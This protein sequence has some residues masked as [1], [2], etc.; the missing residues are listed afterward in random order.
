MHYTSQ[1]EINLPR[2]QMI[3]L[4]DDPENMPKWMAGLLSFEPLSGVPG[5]PGARSKLVFQMGKRK[6]EMR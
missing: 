4:F 1:I 2:A 6:M 3:E 5:T